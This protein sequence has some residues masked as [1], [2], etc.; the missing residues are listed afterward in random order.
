MEENVARTIRNLV[1]WD[2]LRQFEANART[3][4]RLTEEVIVALIDRASKIA[5]TLVS[6]K[7]GLDL[8]SLSPAQEKI[9]QA[10]CE[11]VGIMRQQ[12]K[13][14]GRTLEQLRNRGLL[15]AAER[16]VSRKKTTQGY[17]TLVD[18]DLE[19]MSY[20]QI[21]LDHPSE[22][23]ER[24]IWFSRRTLGLPNIR[25]FAPPSAEILINFVA[26]HDR[27]SWRKHTRHQSLTAAIHEKDGAKAL[28]SRVGRVAIMWEKYGDV[29]CVFVWTDG[30]S[31]GEIFQ[32][33]PDK[34]RILS[35]K[36]EINKIKSFD[37]NKECTL[38]EI[39][40]C[41]SQQSDT[42]AGRVM[43]SIESLPKTPNE[44]NSTTLAR[45]PIWSRDELILALDLYLQH[46]LSPL[47][48]GSAEVTELSDFLNRMGV[49]L[50][51][52]STE[53][54][55]NANGVYMKLMNFRRFDPEYTSDG[56]VGLTRGNKDEEL[57][58][59][60]FSGD[61]LRL[62]DVVRAIHL[63]VEA[64]QSG[65]LNGADES[66]IVEA[67]EGRVLTRMHR[68][69]ERSRSLVDQCKKA[70]LKRHGRL[71]CEACGF[72]FSVK[73]GSAGEGL[74]EAHHTKPVH[75]LVEGDK[76]KLEDLALLCANCHRVVHSTRRWLTVEQVRAAIQ[77]K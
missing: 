64:N 40:D 24:A 33:S 19:E 36:V 23:S 7:T 57:V 37:R 66:E 12:G 39:A 3:K 51:K 76:T 14:P 73:Y 13:Y 68:I 44:E 18:A 71:A 29:R 10:V 16:A 45:N 65:S 77:V 9:V 32:L 60:E 46:R 20:E 21:V 50:G 62:G 49:A 70:A 54:F 28:L 56:K 53:T 31:S 48:K 69:R 47:G 61:M 27:S 2:E 63:A 59:T 5:R 34:S 22:F 30:A 1:S 72:D 26:V 67:E 55:R 75:T 35:A 25:Q 17:Q 74:I 6:E 58:W 43:E 4:N 15:G 38:Q 11:Y 41:F 52:P 42:S 8:T